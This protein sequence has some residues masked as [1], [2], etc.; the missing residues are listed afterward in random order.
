MFNRRQAICILIASWFVL[1]D[2]F[3]VAAAAEV[4]KLPAGFAAV[5]IGEG[6]NSTSLA[7][8]PDGRVLVA[9]KHGAVRVVQD[10]VLLPQP[11]VTLSNVET[12]DE[13]GLDGMVVH[14]KFATNG[15]VYLYYTVRSG[16]ERGLFNRV[17]RYTVRGNVA[18]GGETVIFETDRAENIHNGGAMCFGPDGKLYVGSGEV[19]AGGEAQK[20]D[21]LRGKVLRLNDDGSIPADNPF[22]KVTTGK[23]QA[24]YAFGYRQPFKGAF[25]PGT[26]KFYLNV[27]STSAREA[28]FEVKPGQNGGWPLSEGY[29]TDAKFASPVFAYGGIGGS[30]TGGAFCNSPKMQFP[31]RYQGCYFFMDFM[32]NWIRT[33][34]PADPQKTLRVF[35]TNVDRPVDLAFAPDGSLYCLNRGNGKGNTVSDQGTLW[36]IRC[37]G[38]S[39]PAQLGFTEPPQDTLPGVPFPKG[40]GVAFQDKQGKTLSFAEGEITVTINWKGKSSQIQPFAPVQTIDGVASFSDLSIDTPGKGYTITAKGPGLPPITSSPFEI[41]AK[42]ARPQIHPGRGKFSGPV[43]VRLTT[44]TP[45]AQIHYTSDGSQVTKSS[46]LYREPFPMKQNGTVRALAMREGLAESQDA[47]ESLTI[48]DNQPYGLPFRPEI[49]GVNLPKSPQETPPATLSKTGVFQDVAKLQIASGFVP[50]EVISPL[51]SDGAEKRRWIGLPKQTRIEFSSDREWRFP[52]GTVFVK[53]FKLALDP[54]KPTQRNR[55]ET[56]LLIVDESEAKGFGLTY[57]WRSDQAEADLVDDRGVDQTL[58][59]QSPKGVEKKQMWHFPGRMECLACHTANADFVLG[60]NTRQFNSAVTYPGGKRDNQL[61]TWTYL[62]MFDRAPPEAE[63]EKL[64]TL[65]RLDDQHASLATRV[66]SYL[67]ANCAHCHRPG[68]AQAQFDARFSTP[69]ERSDVIRGSLRNELGLS[70]SK[71]I[72]PRDLTKSML[73]RRLGSNIS[74]QKMPPLAHDVVDAEALKLF[75][76]WISSMDDRGNTPGKQ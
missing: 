21:N 31:K 64:P 62:Q 52:P 19:T 51:W 71:V 5:K 13:Q 25:Q 58:T 75:E 50:Y 43:T 6:L 10:D 14:P 46:P 33:F 47:S 68:G 48:E 41:L 45:N 20:L 26:N 65:T 55:L 66:R 12:N 17:C 18:V 9:E 72:M 8:L 40:M 29:A 36:R 61:R 30:I 39:P 28:I 44:A 38:E 73:H 69:L 35:A 70:G 76:Q 7:I 4:P 59:V 1:L 27:V 54:K 2:F 67:D 16:K 11:L 63:Y 49:K 22:V 53:H 15:Q 3:S 34:D 24:I 56:R 74:T 23:N 37:S 32:G 42:A 60:V 57:K